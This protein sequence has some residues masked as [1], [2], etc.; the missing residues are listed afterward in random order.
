MNS[1]ATP[2]NYTK[3]V[4]EPMVFTQYRV[5]FSDMVLH[6][7]VTINIHLYGE[8]GYS[9]LHTIYYKVEGD[10][11][12]QWGDDDSYIESIIQRELQKLNT[13][14]PAE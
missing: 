8:S 2:I 10:E 13:E 5:V 3:V 11:Y 7:E 9:V 1:L 14:S 12:I 6:K 4:R